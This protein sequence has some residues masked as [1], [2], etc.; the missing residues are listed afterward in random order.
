MSHHNQFRKTLAVATLCATCATALT[1]SAAD[2]PD[3]DYWWPN[4]LSLEP[5]RDSSAS[6][7]PLGADFDYAEAFK[8]LD[9]E[10]L[11][12]DL[13]TLMTTSQDWWPADYGHYGPLFV[14][15]SWHVA[16]TYRSIDGRG[17]VD[18]GM[19]R[20]APLNAWPDNVGLDKAR[21][22]LL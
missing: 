5:L 3:N 6:A 13:R 18:G 20:F 7:D 19:Q 14:R 1:T 22:L 4:R 17:G 11:K 21:R 12:Q 2:A 9:V 8:Q 15:M 16:G 10:T